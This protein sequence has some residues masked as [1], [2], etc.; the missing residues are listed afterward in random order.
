MSS[1]GCFH[2]FEV[3][4]NFDALCWRT[5]S[6]MALLNLEMAEFIQ[7]TVARMLV[8]GRVPTIPNSF[9]SF[10]RRD[11]GF[12]DSPSYEDHLCQET[13]TGVMRSFESVTT[14]TL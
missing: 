14:K 12:N 8:R 7:Q 3:G 4:L 13:A 11:T 10:E 1:I 6:D 5:R 2:G 9:P